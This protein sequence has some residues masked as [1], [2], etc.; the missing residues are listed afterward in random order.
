MSPF[1]DVA[2]TT[3]MGAGPLPVFDGAPPDFAGVI[4]GHRK[5]APKLSRRR[6]DGDT[7]SHR[8]REAL[9]FLDRA[10]SV[11]GG[12]TGADGTDCSIGVRGLSGIILLARRA[13]MACSCLRVLVLAFS[14]QVRV[15][16]DLSRLET[17]FHFLLRS[18]S[19][20]HQPDRSRSGPEG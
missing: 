3:G 6:T 10:L 9:V 7:H 1:R 19:L 4:L 16:G 17:R 12:V 11:G 5:Y 20:Q 2:A 14:R 15:V 18:L 13:A 8:R